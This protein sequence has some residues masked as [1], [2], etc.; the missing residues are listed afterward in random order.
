MREGS[1]EVLKGT[2]ELIV[3]TTVGSEKPIAVQ[4]PL[5]KIHETAMV[6]WP[7]GSCAQATSR[8]GGKWS[9]RDPRATTRGTWGARRFSSTRVDTEKRLLL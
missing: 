6:E 1:L 8:S 3:L 7:A 5:P 9:F 2:L 4:E